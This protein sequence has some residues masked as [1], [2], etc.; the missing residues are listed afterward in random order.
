MTGSSQHNFLGGY[1]DFNLGL[2][3]ETTLDFMLTILKY[4][5]I[6]QLEY[7]KELSEG[8]TL[9]AKDII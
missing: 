7:S 5:R 3:K 8:G 4:L 6:I 1:D 9:V 2:T